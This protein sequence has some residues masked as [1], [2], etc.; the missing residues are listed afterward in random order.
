VSDTKTP[1]PIKPA[2]KNARDN[3]ST[4]AERLIE[5]LRNNRRLLLA[6]L[7]L[8]T[9][10]LFG[11]VIGLVVRDRVTANAFLSV[12]EFE[13]R[14]DQLF[15]YIGS[16]EEE[17]LL[18]QG[19]ITALLD[20]LSV[21]AS[22]NRGFVAASAYRIKAEIF[23]RQEHW[24][25]AQTSWA[26]AA[27]AAPRSYFAPIALFN[28]AAAAEEDDNTEAALGLYT[29]ALASTDALFIA[30]RAQFAIGRL[31]EELGNTEAALDAYRAVL[32][33]WPHDPLFASLAQ[34]RL[35][36]LSN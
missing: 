11:S 29:Q 9:V 31:N 4:A 6:A 17:A 18:R 15:P 26:A 19:E 1:Q 27:A 36:A 2:M 28:A 5:F 3:E 12:D 34:S 25:L 22:R 33:R 23:E 32:S 7:V 24:A 13:Q 14:Y 10:G 35:I 8:I 16:E 30:V 21:F 20:D